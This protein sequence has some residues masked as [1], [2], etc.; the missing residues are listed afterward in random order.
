MKKTILSVI[1]MA[2]GVLSHAESYEG[3]LVMLVDGTT[4]TISFSE[5]PVI[6]FQSD[7]LVVHSDAVSTEFDRLKVARFNY[8]TDLS[9]VDGID[10]SAVTIG[11]NG[12][13]LYLSG[14][15]TDSAIDVYSSDGK[16][17]ESVRATSN[18]TIEISGLPAGVY[19]V[20]VNGVSTKIT[21]QP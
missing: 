3:I 20:S 19:I 2:F 5:K 7:K 10:R 18:H 9:G 13:T 6:K 11:N 16:L 4:T 12:S 17:L 1:L 8:V 21:K 15:P 14:L